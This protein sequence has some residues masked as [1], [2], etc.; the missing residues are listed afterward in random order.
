MH[1]EAMLLEDKISGRARNGD[2][3]PGPDIAQIENTQLCRLSIFPSDC[4][5]QIN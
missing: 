2:D 1:A 3:R 4:R 5:I